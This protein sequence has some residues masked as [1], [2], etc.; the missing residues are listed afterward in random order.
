MNITSEWVCHLP[1]D[2]DGIMIFKVKCLLRE[3]DEKM[4]DLRYFKMH[5]LRRKGLTGKRK[6]GRCNGGNLYCP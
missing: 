3:W 1:E 5:S 6:V 2:I 4:H